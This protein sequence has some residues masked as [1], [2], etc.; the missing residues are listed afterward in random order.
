MKGTISSDARKGGKKKTIWDVTRGTLSLLLCEKRLSGLT[1]SSEWDCFLHDAAFLI[2]SYIFITYLLLYYIT[3]YLALMLLLG[4]RGN[5]DSVTT[6]ISDIFINFKAQRHFIWNFSP[7]IACFALMS[8]LKNLLGFLP[9]LT[10]AAWTHIRSCMCT[11]ILQCLSRQYL[12]EKKCS[13]RASQG[14]GVHSLWFMFL[15]NY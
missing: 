6:H 11:S 15:E 13:W 10:S 1:M 12:Y 2:H 9:H 8:I 7:A 3:F 5:T 4:W 14:S